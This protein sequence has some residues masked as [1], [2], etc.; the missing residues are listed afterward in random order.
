MIQFHGNA[1]NISSHYLSLAWLLHHHYNLITFDYPGYGQ[2]T[3]PDKLSVVMKTA[4]EALKKIIELIPEQQPVFVYGQSLGTLVSVQ[5]LKDYSGRK[6]NG[7]ILEG[8]IYSLNQTAAYVMRQHWL[9]WMLQPFAMMSLPRRYNMK[10]NFKDVSDSIPI[11]LLHSKKDPIVSYKQ[12]EKIYKKNRTNK[13]MEFIRIDEKT[14]I[15]IGNIQ[16]GKYRND[17]LS[18]LSQQTR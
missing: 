4:P 9:T 7:F 12:S 18:F 8:A 10:K 6:V 16:N 13:Q 5:A 17:I 1:E 2:S 15:N 11:L 3:G 14:H